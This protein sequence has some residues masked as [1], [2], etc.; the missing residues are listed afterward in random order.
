MALTEQHTHTIHIQWEPGNGTRY[1]VVLAALEQSFM[2][3][4]PEGA[5]LVTLTGFRGMPVAFVTSKGGLLHCTYVQEKTNLG[6]QDACVVTE[7]ISAV[8]DREFYV[9]EDSWYR[10]SVPEFAPIYKQMKEGATK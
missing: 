1:D 3:H 5:Y 2:G 6:I 7:I 10:E 4:S 8:L 9:V